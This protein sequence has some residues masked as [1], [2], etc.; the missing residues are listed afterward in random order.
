MCSTK[1]NY[2]KITFKKKYVSNNY[3]QSIVNA[4]V[5]SLSSSRFENLPESEKEKII[6]AISTEKVS[7]TVG[8][9]IFD[10]YFTNNKESVSNCMEKHIYDKGGD[11]YEPRMNN[12]FKTVPNFV[13]T[14]DYQNIV[15]DLKMEDYVSDIYK[16]NF[17]LERAVPENIKKHFHKNNGKINIDDMTISDSL[18]NGYAIMHSYI[19]VI[20]SLTPEQIKKNRENDIQNLQNSENMKDM[21]KKLKDGTILTFLQLIGHFVITFG[22]FEKMFKNT[23]VKN[24]Y[25][26]YNIYDV[27]SLKSVYCYLAAKLYTHSV[28]NKFVWKKINNNWKKFTIEEHFDDA[29]L[30]Y[31]DMEKTREH[32]KKMFNLIL[33]FNK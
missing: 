9:E 3:M 10:Y 13:S 20:N 6:K 16:Y 32:G 26:D 7:S 33:S 30:A 4:I 5:G 19:T 15:K 27:T 8:D 31:N 1:I 11:C 2:F 28:E 12:M 23:S 18:F 25:S 24:I 14:T 17:F 22:G 21:K 29:S